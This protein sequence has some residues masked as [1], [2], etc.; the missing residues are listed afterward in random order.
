[1]SLSSCIV[2]GYGDVDCFDSVCKVPIDLPQVPDPSKP[3]PAWLRPV[4]RH[5]SVSPS[6]SSVTPGNSSSISPASTPD[7]PPV[8]S[9]AVLCQ[10]PILATPENVPK[11]EMFE[12]VDF[13]S[14]SLNTTFD[15]P[16]DQSMLYSNEE[17]FDLSAAASPTSPSATNHLSLP[18]TSTNVNGFNAFGDAVSS[19]DF[20]DFDASMQ[21]MMGPDLS[22]LG[23]P[24]AGMDSLI[25]G[26]LAQDNMFVPS[27]LE[28]RCPQI[29][30]LVPTTRLSPIGPPRRSSRF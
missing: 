20:E 19:M 7:V 2:G 4:R 9:N 30:L 10:P 28:L 27:S 15:G 13:L 16:E 11:S 21:S 5:R 22:D 24:S 29:D 3:S 26:G 6:R 17:F 1:M 8:P 12:D 25:G 14:P 18:G 23:L